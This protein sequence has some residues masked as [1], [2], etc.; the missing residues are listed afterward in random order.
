MALGCLFVGIGAL[1]VVLPVL[2]TTPFLLVAAFFFVRSSPRLYH[3]LLRSPLFGPFLRDWQQH[4]GIRPRVRVTAAVVMFAAVAASIV[5]GDL[6][7]P[8]LVL[9]L[10]LAAVGL[11]VVFRLPVIRDAPKVKVAVADAGDQPADGELDDEVRSK[12]D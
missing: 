11:G 3:W 1:G 7:W 5:W 8:L 4:R 10:V 2:P 12:P 9:L 6:S